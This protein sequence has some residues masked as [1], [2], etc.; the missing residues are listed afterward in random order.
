MKIKTKYKN[1]ENKKKRRQKISVDRKM[2]FF[3]A[4]SN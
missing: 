3:F 2:F 4:L 1:L